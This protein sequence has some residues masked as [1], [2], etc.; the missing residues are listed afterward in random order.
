MTKVPLCNTLRKSFKGSVLKIRYRVVPPHQLNQRSK[1]SLPDAPPLWA[2][3]ADDG[4]L[5]LNNILPKKG[6][7]RNPDGKTV[8]RES[9]WMSTSSSPSKNT[10]LFRFMYNTKENKIYR[11]LDESI[12]ARDVTKDFA[13]MRDVNTIQRRKFLLPLTIVNFHI[14]SFAY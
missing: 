7:V 8:A 4:T 5:N 10:R 9:L 12:I 1:M 11:S 14:C 6:S 3:P 2:S 13:V